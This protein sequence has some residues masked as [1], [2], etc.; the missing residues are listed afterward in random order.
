MA[1]VGGSPTELTLDGRS[2]VYVA[3]ADVNR[4]LGGVENEF[5]PNGDGATGRLIKKVIGWSL[6]GGNIE[7]DDDR[8]DQV[9]LKDLAKSNDYF[10]VSVTYPG[11]KVFQGTGQI[12]GEF[13]A[14]SGTASAPISLMGP[15]ELTPQ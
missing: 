4:K 10:S 13:A 15:G 7:I 12:V 11:G 1:A 5:Q 14:S 2:F 6:D 8:D 9:F 3:D